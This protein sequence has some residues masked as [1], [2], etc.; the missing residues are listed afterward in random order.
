MFWLCELYE[1]CKSLGFFYFSTSVLKVFPM[2]FA[3]SFCFTKGSCFSD[4]D[5][6]STAFF[7]VFRNFLK[8]L[9]QIT[10]FYVDPKYCLKGLEN[11]KPDVFNK[12]IKNDGKH[13]K[14]KYG[15]CKNSSLFILLENHIA[16]N[17]EKTFRTDMKILKNPSL[18]QSS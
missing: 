8:R 6:V 15:T 7:D 2:F 14:T 3:H 10:C 17:T 11:K 4:R 12:C 9:L 16:N 5:F 18:S 13:S 1:L